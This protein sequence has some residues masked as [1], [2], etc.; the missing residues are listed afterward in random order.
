[1]DVSSTL[2]WCHYWSELLL[3]SVWTL[4]FPN[5]VLHL[6]ISSPTFIQSPRLLHQILLSH[7]GCHIWDQITEVF[8][9][10]LTSLAGHGSP[11]SK[12]AND[13][14][15]FAVAQ[16]SLNIFTAERCG[17]SVFPSVQLLMHLYIICLSLMIIIFAMIASMTEVVLHRF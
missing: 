13:L 10:K 4:I 2:L 8:R 1:M 14:L 12:H 3:L 7:R 15:A 6:C 5:F 17:H 11:H 9:G 16:C